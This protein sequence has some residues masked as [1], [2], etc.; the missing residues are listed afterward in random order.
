MKIENFELIKVDGQQVIEIDF[1]GEVFD[2]HNAAEF[3]RIDYVIKTSTLRLFWQYYF[4][5]KNIITFQIR[6]DDT[7]YFE[8]FPRDSE[9]T[10]EED[11]CLEEII[12]DEN[13]EFKFMGGM[14]IVVKAEKV[15]FIKSG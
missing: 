13:F 3:L 2:L 11:G 12:L 10:K 4:D 14:R 8:V 5:K 1:L 6:F 9:M 15:I 7:S